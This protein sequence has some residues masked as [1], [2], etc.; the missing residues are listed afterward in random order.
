MNG[1]GSW[2]F[3]FFS[4]F[5]FNQAHLA[6]VKKLAS[7]AAG[8]AEVGKKVVDYIAKLPPKA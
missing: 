5:V 6:S 8:N 2:E 3:R 7:F 4:R 1:G